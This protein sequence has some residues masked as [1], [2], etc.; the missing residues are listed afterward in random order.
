[1]WNDTLRYD[2]DAEDADEY[3]VKDEKISK[4]NDEE[5]EEEL[6]ENKGI[7][8]IYL[9]IYLTLEKYFNNIYYI[10]FYKIVETSLQAPE[11]SKEKLFEVSKDLTSILLGET[12]NES[13]G[14]YKHHYN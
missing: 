5:D 7:I 1:M 8:Y 10:I 4:V 12:K 11:V 6:P 13:T 2:P 9:F 14:N 3:I